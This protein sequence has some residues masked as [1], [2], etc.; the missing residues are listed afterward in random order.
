[1]LGRKGSVGTVHWIP[2][3][4]W[5]H[6]TTL[7]VRDFHGNDRRYV[8]HFL[9]SFP[10]LDYESSTANPSLNRNRLHPVEVMWPNRSL[11]PVIVARVDELMG[12]LDRLEARLTD[13]RT[14]HV[15]FAAAA[16]HHL[17]A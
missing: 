15:A 10:L 3:E 5:P 14:A 8:Y 9:R 4:Y 11:Q 13:A 7:W 2:G 16:I 1:V 17:D 6:D 12:L